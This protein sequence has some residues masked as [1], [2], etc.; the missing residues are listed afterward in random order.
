VCTTGI[1]IVR[2]REKNQF[3]LSLLAGLK[4]IIILNNKIK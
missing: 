4:K 2:E 1:E 3:H